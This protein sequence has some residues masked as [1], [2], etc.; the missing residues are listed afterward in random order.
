MS[1]KNQPSASIN[2]SQQPTGTRQVRAEPIPLIIWGASAKQNRKKNANG[3]AALAEDQDIVF[4][5]R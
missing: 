4:S 5:S 3:P 2:L 1:L